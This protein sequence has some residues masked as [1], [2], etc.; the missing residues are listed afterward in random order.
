[1]N[2]LTDPF[3]R[4]TS[5]S[6]SSELALKAFFAGVAKTSDPKMASADSR[7]LDA[8]QTLINLQQTSG[9]T[10]SLLEIGLTVLTLNYSSLLTVLNL[11]LLAPRGRRECRSSI[12]LLFYY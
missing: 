3:S 11:T 6:S 1:M 8:A 9:I 12:T 10:Q 7:L 5:T 2:Y 4:G